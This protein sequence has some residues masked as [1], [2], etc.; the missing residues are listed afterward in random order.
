M[1]PAFLLVSAMALWQTERDAI[2]R[3]D[4][5]DREGIHHAIVTGR[6]LSA[7]SEPAGNV[8][9]SVICS[10]YDRSYLLAEGRTDVEGRFRVT[11]VSARDELTLVVSAD[12]RHRLLTLPIEAASGRVTDLR[13]LRVERAV[14]AARVREPLPDV[15]EGVF[16]VSEAS[17]TVR[18]RGAPIAGAWIDVEILRRGGMPERDRRVRGATYV[19]DAQGTAR[20]DVNPDEP[21]E[22]FVYA[23]G[24]A[25]RRVMWQS[26]LAIDL[27]PFDAHARF[28]PLAQG[29]HLRVKPAGS[30]GAL[31]VLYPEGDGA[32]EGDLV[33]GAYDAVVVGPSGAALRMVSFAIARGDRALI[34]LDRDDRPVVTLPAP[35]SRCRQA[36]TG[37]S[38]SS[39][40]AAACRGPR[41]P[42][43][44]RSTAA[45]PP[46]S[47]SA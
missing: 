27:A 32:A 20:R 3:L 41:P 17:L 23:P 2:G 31:A 14:A 37:L 10:E 42:A 29:E 33:A 25:P 40:T 46:C 7:E 4:P 21:C 1:L 11:D 24:C 18:A 15:R 34:A 19:T 45:I 13:T 47:P 44:R 26:D 43:R 39:A 38:R 30:P 16:S 12:D 35:R 6:L 28:A 36:I 22:A 8:A 9:V 5:L